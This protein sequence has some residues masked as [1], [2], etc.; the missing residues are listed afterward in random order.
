MDL[1]DR[2]FHVP[3]ANEDVYK[4]DFSYRYDMFEYLVILFGLMNAPSI[5][6]R[7]MNQ[8][9][10][11]LFNFYIIIYLDD[12]LVFSYTKKDHMHDMNAVFK[13]L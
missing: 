1:G 12:I 4:M 9:I 6:C 11:D 13:R 2:Y 10:F 7:V 5:F 3:I 8:V